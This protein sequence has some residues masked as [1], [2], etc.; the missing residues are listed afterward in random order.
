VCLGFEFF[1]EPAGA[2]YLYANSKNVANDSM[3]F[4]RN[5][6]EQAGVA[7]TPGI[8]FGHNK[9]QE[10]VRFAY[11]TGMDQL[12]TGVDAIQRYLGR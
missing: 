11:T 3:E 5:L 9:P 4:S 1:C 6:L 10:H 12:M 8:D 7:I 2:F